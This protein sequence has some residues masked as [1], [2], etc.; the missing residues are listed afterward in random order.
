MREEVIAV[1]IFTCNSKIQ[2]E[3]PYTRISN[4]YFIIFRSIQ[5]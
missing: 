2:W 1:T 5:Q 4:N 3:L